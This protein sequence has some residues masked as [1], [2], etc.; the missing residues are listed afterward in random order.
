[1]H[2]IYLLRLNDGTIYTGRSDD[3]KHRIKEHIR[4]KVC[5]TRSKLPVTL[6]FYEAYINKRDAV[7]RELYLKTGDGRRIIRK[8]L[9]NSLKS[10]KNK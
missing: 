4:G 9:Q 5:S 3:L 1:M 10:S 7:N 6:L 2:Y 8:Q